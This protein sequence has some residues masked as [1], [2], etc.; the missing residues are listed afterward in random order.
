M[1]CGNDDDDTRDI[2]KLAP[3]FL[4]LSLSLSLG[5]SVFSGLEG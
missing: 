4:S 3:E 5:L 1:N 2:S